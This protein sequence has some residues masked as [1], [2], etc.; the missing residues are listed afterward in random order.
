MILITR[1]LEKV[2]RLY[3]NYGKISMMIFLPETRVSTSAEQMEALDS[4]PL[5]YFP[6]FVPR[7][8]FYFNNNAAHFLIKFVS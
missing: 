8:L 4:T 5:F 1:G 2:N 6:S 7:P 3:P